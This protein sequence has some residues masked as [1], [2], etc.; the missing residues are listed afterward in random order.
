MKL[1]NQLV[2]KFTYVAMT[3]IYVYRWQFYLL[4]L[5]LKS[6]LRDFCLTLYIFTFISGIKPYSGPHTF[7][8]FKH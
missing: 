2:N 1:I 3:S 4:L 7:S 5:L 6:N 8:S